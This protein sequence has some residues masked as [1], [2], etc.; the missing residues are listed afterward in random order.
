MATKILYV[1]RN[2]CHKERTRIRKERVES[3]LPFP[4]DVCNLIDSY[5]LMKPLSDLQTVLVGPCSLP[6]WAWSPTWLN[7]IYR[8]ESLVDALMMPIPLGNSAVRGQLVK[9]FELIEDGKEDLHPSP[10]PK[11]AFQVLLQLPD[12]I[13]AVTTDEVNILLMMFALCSRHRFTHGSP[14]DIFQDFRLSAFAEN[15]RR[16]LDPELR[17][18]QILRSELIDVT[19]RIKEMRRM[20]TRQKSIEFQSFLDLLSMSESDFSERRAE[21]LSFLYK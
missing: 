11:L 15:A 6:F 12:Y 1:P 19:F 3:I 4:V 16:F 13:E 10:F 7:Q 18:N 21:M 8:V 14:G 2:L 20:E 9:L 5:L 17:V